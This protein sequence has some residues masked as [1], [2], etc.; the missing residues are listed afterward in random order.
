MKYRKKSELKFFMTPSDML[1]KEVFTE[2][3]E[4]KKMN[5]CLKTVVSDEK[6]Q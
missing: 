1:K 4:L 6:W 2:R 3:S 5:H